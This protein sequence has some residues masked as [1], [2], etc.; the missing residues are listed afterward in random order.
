MAR[1]NEMGRGSLLAVVGLAALALASFGIFVGVAGAIHDG[2][3]SLHDG[4]HDSSPHMH[5]G[6]DIRHLEFV[7]A[8]GGSNPS[9]Q[10]IEYHSAN[11]ASCGNGA[12]IVDDDSMGWLSVDPTEF[13]SSQ[14]PVAITVAVDVSGLAAGGYEGTV[15]VDTS[16]PNACDD[17]SIAVHLTVTGGAGISVSPTSG[18]VTTEA[19]GTDTFDVVLDTQPSA[20]VTIALSSSNAAEGGLSAASLT[21]TNSNWHMQQ[22]VTVTGVDDDIDDGDVAYT[23]VTGAA[24]SADPAYHGFNAADVSLTNSDDDDAGIS[25]SHAADLETTEAG[26][27]ASF[28]IVLDSEPT[29][30]V[31]IALSSS[32]A[33][34]GALNKASVTFDAGDWDV[35]QTVIVTGVD[36]D[37]TDGDIAYSAITAPAT[38]GDPAYNGRNAADVPLTNLDDDVAGVTVSPTAGL[39]TTEAGAAAQFTVVLNTM[40]THDVSISLA[41]SD[42]GEG[43]TNVASLTFTPANWDDAQTVTVTGIDDSDIDG[44]VAYV[45]I[46]GATLS[47]DDD[48]DDLAVSNVS[49]T[50]LDDDSSG[51]SVSPTSGL[52]TT[53]AGGT[54]HFSVVLDT[55]PTHNVTIALASNDPSEGLPS[56]S[57]LVFTPANWNIPQIVIVTGVDDADLDGDRDYT[58]ILGAA[59]SSDAAYAGVNPADVAFTNEDDEEEEDDGRGKIK[60]NDPQG[61]VDKVTICHVPPGN[62]QNAHTITIGAAAAEAHLAQH[63]GDFDLDQGAAARARPR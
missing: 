40:P 28:E 50:N 31:T 57:S 44:N 18:L 15:T 33:S 32:D 21:F 35:P 49:L 61:G 25:V 26:G 60:D 59:A 9:P 34:E 22:T 16:P 29:H 4:E 52:K 47:T 45:V 2:E 62:D 51:I 17:L 48:Y 6:E 13:N 43:V 20:D 14:S 11:A 55:Q 24:S 42:A 39:T 36:D 7:A 23:V 38:S 27:T 58:V 56:T 3:H 8:V 63:E 10:P 37:A 46:T 53:E 1:F 41:S 54:A 5:D 30:S 19:G 12:V